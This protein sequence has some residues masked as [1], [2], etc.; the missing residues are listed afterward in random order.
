[1]ENI[2]EL[3]NKINMFLE[4]QMQPLSFLDIFIQ[5]I[6]PII[7]LLVIMGGAGA[8]LYKYFSSKNRE[9]YEKILSEV[10]A[11]LYQYFVKQEL[12]CYLSEITLD[13]HDRPVMEFT[14][15]K[16]STKIN[17]GE[18]SSIENK[19]EKAPVLQLNREE[20]LKVLDTVN[21]GL[22]SK[23]LYT[24]LSMYKVLVYVES[25]NIKTSNEFLTA[26]ILKVDVENKLRKEIF[27]GYRKY[28]KK[29]GLDTVTS[30]DFYSLTDDQIQFKFDISEE[31]KQKLLRDIQENPDKY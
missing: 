19:T 12:F 20:F 14:S 10:Y 13:Y 29:L 17:F 24:L 21:I 25:G 28:H 31:E 4:S 15:V 22:A 26:A 2:V 9:I 30:N 23:E 16:Q 27:L 7:Q 18:K 6:S 8:G 3:I 11:P 5:Y 1:M